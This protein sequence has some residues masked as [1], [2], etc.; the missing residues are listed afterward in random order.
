[1]LVVSKGVKARDVRW[2]LSC[3]PANVVCGSFMMKNNLC[4][5]DEQLY[6]AL[7]GL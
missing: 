3:H 4:I 7:L 6:L 2:N 5:K 1:M